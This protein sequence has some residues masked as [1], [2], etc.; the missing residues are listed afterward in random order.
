VFV[1]SPV[2][3]PVLGPI[4][5]KRT[6]NVAAVNAPIPVPLSTLSS[7]VPPVAEA[8]VEVETVE[9]TST[10]SGTVR[11][12]PTSTKST[13]S[14]KSKSVSEGGLCCFSW[15]YELFET[16]PLDVLVLDSH[17]IVMIVRMATR[18]DV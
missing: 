1:P 7:P 11:G 4:S 14:K 5:G 17:P 13:K 18:K 16:H 12:S 9:T 3:P 10:E 15:L 8:P 6:G 2:S